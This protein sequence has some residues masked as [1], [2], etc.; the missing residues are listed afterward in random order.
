MPKVISRGKAKVNV[1]GSGFSKPIMK[2]I[3]LID[4][5]D[6]FYGHMTVKKARKPV[7]VCGRGDK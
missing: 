7:K 6:G 1:S 3:D 5:D 2:E 4:Y